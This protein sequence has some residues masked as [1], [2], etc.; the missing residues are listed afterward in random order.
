MKAEIKITNF[1]ECEVTVALTMSWAD[2]QSLRSQIQDSVYPSY[3]VHRAI[4][5]VLDEFQSKTAAYITEPAKDTQ[6]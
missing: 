2:L 1:G 6:A 3:L 5:R 4:G